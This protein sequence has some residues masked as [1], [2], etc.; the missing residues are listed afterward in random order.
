MKLFILSLFLVASTLAEPDS[1]PEGRSEADAEAWYTTYGAWPSWYT[2]Y[3]RTHPYTYGVGHY[4]HYLGKRSADSEAV[5]SADSDALY[6]YNLHNTW[7]VGYTGYYYT[8]P[9]AAYGYGHYLGKRSADSEAVSSADSD[10]LYYYNLHNTWPVGYTGYYN[11]YPY[12]YGFGGH[13]GVYGRK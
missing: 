8:H 3:Y 11:T 9:Y 4:G 7:P 5:S 13:Y 2:G 12:T 6:Y 10:A 1:K